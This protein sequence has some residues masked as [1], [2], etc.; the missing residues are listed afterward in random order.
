MG[1]VRWNRRLQTSIIPWGKQKDDN[2]PNK[3]FLL[4]ENSLNGKCV[5]R[6]MNLVPEFREQAGEASSAQPST[7]GDDRNASLGEC[8]RPGEMLFRGGLQNSCMAGEILTTTKTGWSCKYDHDLGGVEYAPDWQ[9]P[10]LS[11]DV[12]QSS[13]NRKL[14]RGLWDV[15][16]KEYP[17]PARFMMASVVK[18]AHLIESRLDTAG[19]DADAV[20]VQLLTCVPMLMENAFRKTRDATVGLTT[21]D[22]QVENAHAVLKETHLAQ[23][24]RSVLTPMDSVTTLAPWA[25]NQIMA[26]V[27]KTVPAV[28]LKEVYILQKDR[29]LRHTLGSDLTSNKDPKAGDPPCTNT[30]QCTDANG[31]CNYTCPNGHRPDYGLCEQNCACCIPEGDP[32]CTNTTQCTDANG[33]CDYTCP[34]G[35][36]PDYNLCEQ[37]CAC[38]IPEEPC[39]TNDQCLAVGECRQEC[40]DG[41]EPDPNIICDSTMN[42]SCCVKTNN[43]PCRNTT[44]CLAAKGFCSDTCPPNH[45]PD[46]AL[47]EE[48]CTC[49]IPIGDPPC[50]N[51]TQCTDANGFC[52]YTCPNGH[53]PDYNLCEQ[54][55]ACCIPEDIPPC[56]NTTHCLAAKGFCSDTCPPNH[57]PDD[58]LCEENCT[59]CI[60]IDNQPCRNT[61]DCLAAK[62]FCSDTCPPNHR[63]DDALCEENCTCCIPIGDPPCTNTT[64]CTDANGFCNYTCPNGHRPDYNLCEQNC[65]CCI[66]E[67]IL[68]C[69]NTTH[70]LAAKGFCSDTCPPNHRPDD[71]LCEENCTCCVPIEPCPTNDQCLAV[72]ECRQECLDGEE[73][74]PN[75]ICDSTMNCSC[76]VKTNNQPCRN[77][78]QCLDAKGFCRDTCPPNYRPDDTLCEENCTCCIQ[79]EPCPTTGQCLGVGECRQE[80]LDGEEPDPNIFCD[81]TM[82]CSCC[83]KT[84]QSSCNQSDCCHSANGYCDVSCNPAEIGI[85]GLCPG[86]NCQCCIDDLQCPQ[87]QSCTYIHSSNMTLMKGICT[88]QCPPHFQSF[89]DLCE[90]PTCTC[91]AQQVP[92]SSADCLQLGGYC[93]SVQSGIACQGFTFGICDN[94]EYCCIPYISS[95][96]NDN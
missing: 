26:S 30:T 51:T 25:I 42:C 75:I 93:F 65:A 59:C 73:P 19:Q 29:N 95:V 72:G 39:P 52:D 49:C 53:R 34:N 22:A 77:T 35:H 3:T 84:N 10:I 8:S 56:T 96:K 76:C 90:R 37:N 20:D 15:R 33:F 46:D 36:R 63:P 32:P 83:V 38:C 40:L 62:G 57:R 54:N 28:F 58:A 48:N 85:P 9:R 23:T 5:P 88:T 16:D 18:P 87:T 70:C 24:Q 64:Q 86:T 50:T 92:T 82:N 31:F 41:E 69:T 6:D 1:Q 7:Y 43:Q 14:S 45:R 27:N 60:P 12:S 2:E 80:C 68:P 91:C 13:S 47:C 71:A 17:Q 79:I 11:S 94:N 74:D 89:P 44:D 21:Q 55:C 78:T 66:P 4:S 81:S 61:T 67:D